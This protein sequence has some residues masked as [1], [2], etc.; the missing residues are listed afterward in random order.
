MIVFKEPVDSLGLKITEMTL[1][2]D[3]MAQLRDIE[4]KVYHI[5]IKNQPNLYTSIIRQL[6][7]HE[8]VEE[9]G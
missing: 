9:I 8:K 3:H 5:G 7:T 6:K 1:L 2:T 4:G